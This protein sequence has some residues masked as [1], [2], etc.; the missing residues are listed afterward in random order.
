MS[1]ESIEEYLRAIYEFNEKGKLAKNTDLAKRLDIAPSSV[2]QM[3]QKLADE[4][5]VVYE[6][7]R[8]IML[9]GKGNAIARKVVRKHGLLER[10][11][12]NFLGLDKNK[13]HDDADRLEHG[14]SDEAAAALCKA[15]EQPEMS[16]DEE[17]QIPLCTLELEDCNQ[18]EEARKEDESFKPITELSNLSPGEK[19]VVVFIRGGTSACQ[20]LLDMG[21]TQ[22][23]EVTVVNAAPFK[24]PIEVAV[25]GSA[26]ALGRGLARHVF[27]EVEVGHLLE[28]RLHPHGPYHERRRRGEKN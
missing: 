17:S 16:H 5:L 1:G 10:F 20:R 4:G 15:L 3:I 21:L 28:E 19:G 18:C 25:R 13:A 8:G 2:T 14:L 27:V 11:L 24:G 7:Y 26:L 12:H 23:T 9:T 6:P 22:G